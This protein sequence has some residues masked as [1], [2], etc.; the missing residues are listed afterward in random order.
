MLFIIHW[1]IA[2]ENRNAV[3][4]RFAKNGGAAP[5]SLKVLGRWYAVGQLQGFAVVEGDDLNPVLEWTLDWTDLMQMQ[6]C[7]AMTDEQMAPLLLAAV[8]KM[9]L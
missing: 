1:T 3:M 9:A 6:V 2:P 8:N 5:A 4:A 7:P